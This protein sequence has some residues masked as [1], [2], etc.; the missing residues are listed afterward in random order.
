MA[1][2]RKGDDQFGLEESARKQASN[3]SYN[4]GNIESTNAGEGNWPI[5]NL[6][7]PVSGDHLA[8][9]IAN[10]NN[11]AAMRKSKDPA[12]RKTSKKVVDAKMNKGKA[13]DLRNLTE[14]VEGLK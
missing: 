11:Y 12:D 14:K 2:Y 8:R 3:E 13:K 10:S 5:S 6:M 4:R 7:H 1:I 9:G